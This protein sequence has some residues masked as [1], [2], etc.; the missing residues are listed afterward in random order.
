M[1][2]RTGRTM[3]FM[4]MN[5]KACKVSVLIRLCGIVTLIIILVIGGK[6]SNITGTINI[7]CYWGGM[8]RAGT[9]MTWYQRQKTCTGM[10]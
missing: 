9:T 10:N 3:T 8:L 7:S 5:W 1:S 4:N 2:L 6:T